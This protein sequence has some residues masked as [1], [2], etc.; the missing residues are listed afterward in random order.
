MKPRGIH[1]G[2]VK[3]KEKEGEERRELLHPKWDF[4]RIYRAQS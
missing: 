4:R 1:G 2:G 3:G